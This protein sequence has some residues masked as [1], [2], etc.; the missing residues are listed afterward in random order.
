VA[1]Q[2]TIPL[3]LGTSIKTH[4]SNT[5]HH[6]CCSA[7]ITNVLPPIHPLRRSSQLTARSGRARV[8]RRPTLARAGKGELTS[9]SPMTLRAL[10]LI[11]RGDFHNMTGGYCRL[12]MSSLSPCRY[13]TPRNGQKP[14]SPALVTG[15]SIVAADPLSGTQSTRWKLRM[16]MEK[17]GLGILRYIPPGRWTCVNAFDKVLMQPSTQPLGA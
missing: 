16:L 5:Y 1:F 17:S 8:S 4:D 12:P 6:Q 13:S 14:C 10:V 7:R 3:A 2:T 11:C 15:Y 9:G